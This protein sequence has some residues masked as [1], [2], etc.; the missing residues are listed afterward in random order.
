MAQQQRPLA[1][2]C[3]ATYH[4]GMEFL[5]AC[6]QAGNIVYLVTDKKLEHKE[7]GRENID[8]IFYLE[9]NTNTRENLENM[10]LGISYIMRSRYIDRIVSLDDFDVEKGA[11]LRET[12]RIDGMGI[13]TSQ[14]FRDKLAMRMRAK[15]AGILVP[16]FSA[17]FHDET[18]T[19]YLKSVEGPWVIKPRSE[20]SA[21]GIKKVHNLDEAWQVIHS[22]GNTRHN[23]LIEQFKPGD[24]FHVDGLFQEGKVIF[25]NA[26]RY[27][28]P[29]MEV[30]HQGGIFR[31]VSMPKDTA[32]DKALKALNVEVMNAFRMQTSAFHSEYIKSREDGKF[33]FLETSARVGGANLV[34]M[35]EFATGINL[36]R[37]WVN[38]ETALATGKKYKLPKTSFSPAG[39]IVSL[40]RYEYPDMTP[41]DDDE[42]VWKME[43]EQHIG[44]IVKA[45][46]AERVM[47]LLEKY[48]TMIRN[49]YH[50]SAPSPDKPT[51]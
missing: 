34:E 21:A 8:E 42:I 6:K 14:Y 47:E 22:L 33:Y 38:M 9:N 27:V 16:P 39:I 26:S 51:D 13:T 4:K 24:V 25:D 23:Y 44:L 17:L 40:S 41:F 5:R 20:A 31:S 29:P 3:I 19:E 12:F 49:D 32:D 50:A 10:V 48:T 15:S 18:I 11:L 36:W 37:E 35:V 28:N 2:L 43:K 1:F 7:W 45:K 46:K 30:A